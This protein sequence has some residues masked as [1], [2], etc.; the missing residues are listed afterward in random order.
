MAILRNFKALLVTAWWLPVAAI[1]FSY[2]AGC[3]HHHH[4]DERVGIVD[5]HG[6]RHEGSYDADHHWHGGYYNDRH[7][8]H[9]DPADWRH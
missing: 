1:C 4:D 3:E 9:E 2:A 5:E 7:E 8:Y 6:W